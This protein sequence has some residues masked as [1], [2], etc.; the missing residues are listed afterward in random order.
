MATRAELIAKFKSYGYPE[1]EAR[2]LADIQLSQTT[3]SQ[4]TDPEEPLGFVGGVG[5]GVRETGASYARGVGFLT[6]GEGTSV[7]R[8]FE[9]TAERLA[10]EDDEPELTGAGQ[11]GRLVGRLG[12]EVAATLGGVGLAARG[13]A[14]I[15][16]RLV[17]ALRAPS[18]AKRAAA[19]A[20]INL[21]VDVVQG[22]SSEEGL[23]LPGRAG[24]VAENIALSG[25]LGSLESIARRS[26][27]D[28]VKKRKRDRESSMQ[29]G[30]RDMGSDLVPTVRATVPQRVE[31]EAIRLRGLRDKMSFTDGTLDAE[32]R[33]ISIQP[34]IERW[35]KGE[36]RA[37]GVL[38]IPETKRVQQEQVYIADAY[39][40]ALAKADEYENIIRNVDGK[41]TA[42][43]VEEATVFRDGI[44]EN[45]IPGLLWDYQTTSN[46]LSSNARGA[47]R[48]LRLTQELPKMLSQF[49]VKSKGGGRALNNFDYRLL[50][51]HTVGL[52]D[53]DDLSVKNAARL[54]KILSGSDEAVKQKELAEFIASLNK[55]TWTE[56]ILDNRRAGLL[57]MPA[58]WIRNLVGS[59]ESGITELIEHPIAKLLDG[60]AAKKMG[61][62]PVF[63]PR[64]SLD[65]VRDYL[66]G[67]GQGLG[68]VKKSWRMYLAGVDPEDPLKTLSRKIDYGTV[69]D[70]PSA[71][72]AL[73]GLQTMNNTVYGLIAM[74]DKPFFE[75]AFNA[76]LKERALARTLADPDVVSGVIKKSDK[77]AFDDL[78]AKYYQLVDR[79]AAKTVDEDIVMATFDALDATFKTKTKT[80]E[81][82]RSMERGGGPLGVA[83]QFLIPFP[84][85]PQNIVRKALERV[86]ILGA[87]AMRLSGA[88]EK[89]IRG[90][91]KE[92]RRMGFDVSEEAVQRQLRRL[93]S[94]LFA[95]Q[96]TGSAAT[97]A[98]YILHKQGSLTT[99]Y[100]S[101]IGASPEER[102]EAQRRE[103]TGEG[104][105]SLR[106]G[107]T[108]YSLASLGTIAPLLAMGAAISSLEDEK[109]EEL[110]AEDI[111]GTA[112]FSALASAGELPLLTGASDAIDLIRGQGMARPSVAGRQAATL[113]PASGALR[114]ASYALEDVGVRQPDTFVEGF[115]SSLPGLSKDVAARVNT[116]GET[117]P[118]V[119]PVART[120]NP[121][122]PRSV[123]TGPLYEEMEAAGY[124][125]TMVR[126][127]GETRGEFSARR[128]EEGVA[129][130]EILQRI[131]DSYRQSTGL[132]LEE[133]AADPQ[134]SQRLE[135]ALDRALTRTR[136]AATR[137]RR[138]AALRGE[139]T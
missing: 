116:L 64:G 76:S 107:D 9:R 3:S 88:Y 35:N 21:P 12:S 79:D 73:R 37:K 74:G 109:D 134:Q 118:A 56:V 5:R 113:L 115:K 66:E 95:K 86:P 135:R 97:L 137:R 39:Q 47:G 17:R 23:V 128:Q 69:T 43:Q 45:E 8:A 33:E 105:L 121:L 59:A 34:L 48:A 110:L 36:I 54:N 44:Y 60:Y 27:S 127:R 22:L 106:F 65:K 75:A 6:G 102:E 16:P 114:A 63:G 138:A 120:F 19:T 100:R 124:R 103:L 122:T 133:I 91:V 72:A 62:Q 71:Q 41:F 92:F 40:D 55:A 101:P 112:S 87:G 25:G 15:A 136:S 131:L 129:E 4:E 2:R 68:R 11:A 50:V 57:S 99:A 123:I 80:G 85:T 14:R 58:S 111:L 96:I 130:R 46:I 77:K 117:I 67:A 10:D 51:K 70:N 42:K 132:T 30:A 119:S 93:N 78:F 108:S 32:A 26:R 18:R 53:L 7:G 104:A 90:H 82:I 49:G 28:A 125:P 94:K 24:A 1:S 38:S 13:A 52:R 89:Q 126:R 31:E 61:E 81:L 84:N 20:G 98:G 83:A 139:G 29:I